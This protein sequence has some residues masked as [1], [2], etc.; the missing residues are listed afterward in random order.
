MIEDINVVNGA[1]PLTET[2][3]RQ[4]WVEEWGFQ[5]YVTVSAGG[6]TGWG[7]ILASGGNTREPYAALVDRLAPALRGRDES[8]TDELWTAMRRLTYSGGY[9]V[10]TGAISGID[11]ALWDLKSR[12]EGKPLAEVLGGRAR[13]VPRY[14]SLSR[15]QKTD[16]A[17]AV[18]GWLLEQ[19]YTTIKLHQSGRDALEA[20]RRVRERFG[21]DF[22]LAADLNCA[23]P[24][25]KALE[26]MKRTRRHELK[27]VE[28]P[29]WPPDDFDSLRKLN[30][31]G[32]V[33][34]G[35]NFFS[36]FEF[37][38]LI[39]MDALTYYQ[40]DIA[41]IGGVTPALDILKL[42]KRHGAEV[43]FHNRPDNGWVST[44]G[45]AH[46][47]AALSPRSMV[48]S[49]P[50]EIPREYFEFH[51]SMDKTTITPGG[52]GLGVA[53]LGSIPLSDRSKMLVFHEH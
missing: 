15:Y 39:Q 44:I 43:A 40:P 30:K 6:R 31:V 12:E 10:T 22:D 51:G 27:W 3:P 21:H 33:A 18:V 37:E 32:P 1:I 13:N 14:A 46:L 19:G 4:Q 26:F 52:A 38:R 34:A 11:M 35:E 8:E 20:I 53:P 49:P 41:K 45:S 17:V 42:A 25:A 16:D 47:A 28:E 23:F 36:F 9:G 2:I 50:N 7:E 24:Y 48:E 5:L 29:L